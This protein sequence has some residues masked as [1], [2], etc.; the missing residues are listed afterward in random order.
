MEFRYVPVVYIED[1]SPRSGP[2]LGGSQLVL[3]G[4]GFLDTA[5]LVCAFNSVSSISSSSSMMMTMTTTAI[6]Q[7][8]G[9]VSCPTPSGGVLPVGPIA[10]QLSLNNGSDYSNALQYQAYQTPMITALEPHR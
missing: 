9:Q 6:Y 10:V 7:G 3:S 5:S 1:L 8:P 2:S 4:E